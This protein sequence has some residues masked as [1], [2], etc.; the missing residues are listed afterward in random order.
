ME[1]MKLLTVWPRDSHDVTPAK[2]DLGETVTGVEE[3]PS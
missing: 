3:I 2:V 1:I